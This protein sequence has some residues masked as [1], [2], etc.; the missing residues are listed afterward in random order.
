MR[1]P[2]E[3]VDQRSAGKVTQADATRRELQVNRPRDQSIVPVREWSVEGIR[4]RLMAAQ[5]G[6]GGAFRLLLLVSLMCVIHGTQGLWVGF[7]KNTCPN[8]ETIVTRKRRCLF[9]SKPTLNRAPDRRVAVRVRARWWW[10][11]GPRP[12]SREAIAETAK[13]NTKG[14]R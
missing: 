12:D 2:D 8:A 14:P 13:K 7:Y 11:R 5:R 3:E 9:S 4:V 6:R 10:Q 1:A